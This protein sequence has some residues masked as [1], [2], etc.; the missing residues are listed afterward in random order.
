MRREN[1][2][3]AQRR[4]EIMQRSITDLEQ[5]YQAEHIRRRH[6]YSTKEHTSRAFRLLREAI[7]NMPLCK[8]TKE[9][10][11]QWQLWLMNRYPAVS[12]VNTFMV[13]IRPVFRWAMRQDPPWMVEDIFKVPK[14]K[15]SE[16]PD[17]IYSPQEFTQ[18]LAIA[19]SLW[20]LRIR[21]AKQCG[22]RKGEVVHLRFEDVDLHRMVVHVR[23]R[24]ETLSQI[25]WQAKGRTCRTLPLPEVIAGLIEERRK[26]LPPTQIYM[27]MTDLRY[28]RLKQ[29][30]RDGTM[31][32]RVR[33]TPDE[34]FHC[35]GNL[36]KRARIPHGTFKGLRTTYAT[37]MAEGGVPQHELA[38]LMGHANPET[39]AKYYI[40]LRRGH[41]I[42]R[43]RAI[44]NADSQ[45]QNVTNHFSAP[46]C[47]L[48]S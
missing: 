3:A 9:H 22:L 20:A 36:L 28:W 1:R 33:I 42:E 44:L 15:A 7:G 5:A 17:R 14:L 13:T 4:E 37:E 8:L 10:A 48:T 29:M 12:S 11:E 6:S 35:F 40:Q 27:N 45:P 24:R 16:E 2:V 41:A 23:K 39:T 43:A 34:N 21:L 32:D 18:M 46:T 19:N 38:Y 26:E 30:L 25:G 31:C 47:L